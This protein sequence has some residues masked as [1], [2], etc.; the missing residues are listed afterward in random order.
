MGGEEERVGEG[1]D[2]DWG[3]SGG[4]SIMGGWIEVGSVMGESRG[5][6]EWARGLAGQLSAEGPKGGESRRIRPSVG[7]GEGE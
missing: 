6:G 4:G 7:G 1:R 5:A 2:G 3:T